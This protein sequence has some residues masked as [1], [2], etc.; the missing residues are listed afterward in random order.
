MLG[1]IVSVIP[2]YFHD[3][4][5]KA[6]ERDLGSILDFSYSKPTSITG[7]I[8]SKAT[9]MISSVLFSNLC[10]GSSGGCFA[11]LGGSF[12]IL[13]C[14]MYK[15][16]YKRYE[17]Y[18]YNMEIKK[19]K[20][21]YKEINDINKKAQDI[22]F[23]NELM[24]NFNVS[25]PMFIGIYKEINVLYR[26]SDKSLSLTEVLTVSRRGI[27]AHVQ[28]SCFGLIWVAFNMLMFPSR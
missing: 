25:L 12:Y 10:C 19:N 24:S 13:S 5:K 7:R 15:L 14:K 1:G 4:Q 23:Y 2:S 9:D 18:K 8:K 26:K 3:L 20:N 11:L 21:I 22:I 16:L 27:A 6:N 17:D 28:G